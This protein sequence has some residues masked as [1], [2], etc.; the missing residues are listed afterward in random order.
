MIKF[1]CRA[2][3]VIGS[4]SESRT[5]CLP[6]MNRLFR[7]VELSCYMVPARGICTSTLNRPVLQ[8]VRLTRAQH[9]HIWH[10][11][12]GS[13]LQMWESRS[14]VYTNFTTL[15]CS[16][17][18]IVDFYLKLRRLVIFKI[19]NIYFGVFRGNRTHLT[20]IKSS[21]HYQLCYEYME[22]QTRFEL[23]SPAWKAGTLPN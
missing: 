17:K 13:N 20:R 2:I 14:H 1:I 18:L 7:P 8:T 4:K 19:I 9:W 21:V 15:I 3:V 10:Q 22:Q 16:S 12:K 6:G 23:A 11:G 5:H